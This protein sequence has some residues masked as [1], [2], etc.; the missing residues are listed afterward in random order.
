M[1]IVSNQSK[2][3][4]R[5]YTIGE[6]AEILGVNPSLIRF[7]ESEFNILNFKKSK[8]GER[9]FTTDDIDDLKMIYYLVKKKGYTLEG[10]K[11]AI[12]Q[13]AKHIKQKMNTV[14]SLKK[15]KGFLQMLRNELP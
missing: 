8:S 9:K 14:A 15:V 2:I 7:W 6:V 10:A 13:D 3:S 4:K 1:A 11:E 12:K 5:Y